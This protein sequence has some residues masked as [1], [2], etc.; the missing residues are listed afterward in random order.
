MDEIVNLVAQKVGLPADKAQMAVNVILNHLKSKAP[1]LSGPLDQLLS[2]G[3]GGGAGGPARFPRVWDHRGP[4]PRPARGPG[5]R[6]RLRRLPARH[7]SRP[8]PLSENA[9]SIRSV[10]GGPRPP[11]AV[12]DARLDQRKRPT[13]PGGRRPPFCHMNLLSLRQ[14][15]ASPREQGRARVGLVWYVRRSQGRNRNPTHALNRL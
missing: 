7:Q 14:E 13:P 11:G 2:G 10:N 4:G 1:A 9:R 3:D 15:P 6:D 12:S 8:T 5:G